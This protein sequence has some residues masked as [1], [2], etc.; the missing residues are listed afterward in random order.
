MQHKIITESHALSNPIRTSKIQ[1]QQ[2]KLQVYYSPNII[3]VKG[4]VRPRTGDE[5]PEGVQTY[6]STLPSTSALDGGG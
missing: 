5:G 1:R 4:K 3:K 6:S 2:H